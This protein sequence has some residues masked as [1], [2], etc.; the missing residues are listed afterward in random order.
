MEATNLTCRLYERSANK[1]WRVMYIKNVCFGCLLLKRHTEVCACICT[2]TSCSTEARGARES[3]SRGS[4]TANGT[5]VL[6][7]DGCRYFSDSGIQGFLPPTSATPYQWF[8]SFTS[9]FRFRSALFRVGDP[10]F[11]FLSAS[12]P[13]HSFVS[14]HLGATWHFLQGEGLEVLSLSPTS[15][16]VVNTCRRHLTLFVQRYCHLPHLLILYHYM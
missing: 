12:E 2:A 7:V 3:S 14:L 11:S 10:G 13:T 8:F 1:C 5:T 15:G 4:Q 6:R 16:S 9:M